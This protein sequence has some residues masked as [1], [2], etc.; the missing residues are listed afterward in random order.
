MPLLRG[1]RCGHGAAAS[2]A[3]LECPYAV[4]GLDT[5]ASQLQIKMRY[6]ELAKL[7]HPDAQAEEAEDSPE[8][9]VV[10]TPSAPST[11]F[12]RFS[13]AYRRLSS[14]EERAR[15]DQSRVLATEQRRAIR[16]TAVALAEQGAAV[17]AVALFFSS[18]PAEAS[19]A[20]VQCAHDVLVACTDARILQQRHLLAQ[21]AALRR[22]VVE[23][24]GDSAEA[25]NAWFAFC[26]RHGQ[27]VDALR[28]YKQA[29]AAGFEQSHL[30]QAHL[31]QVR[32]YQRVKQA[33]RDAAAKVQEPGR[34]DCSGN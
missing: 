28:A 4:L 10:G 2:A 12:E 13:E 6:Y 1:R 9:D 34:G 26:L 17:E 3:E 23:G 31:R 21:T 22:F 30:M 18:S 14:A 33:Q 8:P 24:G 5:S 19:T 20:D 11:E 7:S 27:N 32:H 16:A 25:C 15:F 29:E